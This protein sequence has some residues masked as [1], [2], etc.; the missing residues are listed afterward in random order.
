M[1]T[2]SYFLIAQSVR[3]Q[4]QYLHFPFSETFHGRGYLRAVVDGRVDK[5]FAVIHRSQ[6]LGENAG[7]SADV[8]IQH[9]G[10]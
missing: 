2:F 5:A 6:G 7:R 3:H 1:E 9:D 8:L 10:G 4:I